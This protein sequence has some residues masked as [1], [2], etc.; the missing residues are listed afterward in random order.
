MMRYE[1]VHEFAGA[2]P[3]ASVH[4]VHMSLISVRKYHRKNAGARGHQTDEDCRFPTPILW[5]TNRDEGSESKLTYWR[6]QARIPPVKLDNFRHTEA[7]LPASSIGRPHD[8]R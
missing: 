1:C 3:K 4:H 6:L 7:R 8:H 5:S 2:Y